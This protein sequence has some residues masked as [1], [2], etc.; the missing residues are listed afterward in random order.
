NPDAKPGRRFCSHRRRKRKQARDCESAHT[1]SVQPR[2]ASVIPLGPRS[3]YDDTMGM[4]LAEK[5]LSRAADTEAVAGDTVVARIDRMM[6]HEGF[7]HV[8]RTLG[9]AGVKRVWDPSRMV[10]VLDHAVP[11]P[12]E[13]TAKSH[14]YIREQA[15]HFG[16]ERFYDVRGGI[17]HQ[18]M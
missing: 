2:R 17:S 15:E 4:T 7:R 11:A 3:V 1:L 10:I 14:T 8:A 12:D 18:V 13:N 16:I 5:I 9:E 6:S